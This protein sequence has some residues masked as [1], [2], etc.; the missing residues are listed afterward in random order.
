MD[1]SNE[2][3][4]SRNKSI[5]KFESSKEDFFESFD[6]EIESLINESNLSIVKMV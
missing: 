5:P 2:L 6:E 3:I 4:G 1:Q